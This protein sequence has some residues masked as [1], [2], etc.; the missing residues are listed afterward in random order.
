MCFFPGNTHSMQTL[1]S[2]C[3]PKLLLSYDVHWEPRNFKEA[4]KYQE[5]RDAMP[6][7]YNALVRNST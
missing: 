3:K 5:W 4:N 7:E 2:I 1:A 6:V